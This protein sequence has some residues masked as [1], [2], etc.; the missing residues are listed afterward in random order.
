MQYVEA[1][2]PDV[3]AFDLEFRLPEF[4]LPLLQNLPNFMLIGLYAASDKVLVLSSEQP[5]VLTISD[6]V[7]VIDRKATASNDNQTVDMR[8]LAR[9]S[10][11]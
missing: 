4:V 10:V 7:R 3:V 5:E 11:F 2:S 9:L 8:T 6:L 1:Q